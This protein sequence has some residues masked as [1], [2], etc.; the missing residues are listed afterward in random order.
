LKG[1]DVLAVAPSGDVAVVRLVSGRRRLEYP[2]G[3]ALVE[4]TGWIGEPRFSPRGDRIAFLDHP[5]DGDDGGAVALVD[6]AGKKSTLTPVFASAKGLAWS[7]DG[8]EIWFTAAETGGNRA[9]RAVKPSGRLRV[10]LAGAGA[11]TLQD[12]SRDG[13]VLTTHDLTRVGFVA[14]GP[15]DPRERDLSWFDW[16]LLADLS[17]DGRTALFS[18]S[19]EGGG[20]GYSVFIRGTDGSPAVRLGEGEAFSLSP[21]GKRVLA[22]L[23]PTADQQLVIYPTGAG[24]PNLLSL[25]NLR[26]RAAIWLADSRRFLMTAAEPGHDSRV[27]LGDSDGGAPRPLTPEGYRAPRGVGLIDGRRF[28][29]RG[30]NEKVYVHSIEGGAPVPVPGISPADVI[31]GPGAKDGTAYVRRGADLPARIARLDLASGREEPYRDL[32]PADPTG[33]VDLVTIRIT[34]DGR[35]YASSYGRV[36]SDLY[37]VEGLK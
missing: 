32:V 14:R 18:E 1:A 31:L 5:V 4:T 3:K 20:A 16:S 37:L 9:L 8:S 29:T 11:F 13:R 21:D 30:P 10:L 22:L 33:I 35:S 12:V 34:R 24:E 7:P 36:L 27:Y 17:E 2:V 23:H 26:V 25:P 6:L 28:L 15:A 19:G